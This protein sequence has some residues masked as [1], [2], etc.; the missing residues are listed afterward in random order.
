MDDHFTHALLV[1]RRF[2]GVPLPATDWRIRAM[3]RP[4]GEHIR[5]RLA[6][7]AGRSVLVGLPTRYGREHGSWWYAGALRHTAAWLTSDTIPV[8]GNESIP[9]VDVA[10]LVGSVVPETAEVTLDDGIDL[11]LTDDGTLRPP[12]WWASAKLIAL[13]RPDEPTTLAVHRNH[14]AQD[15]LCQAVYDLT[16]WA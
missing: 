9:H 1:L 14:D 12:Q 15:P 5:I 3:V 6:D 16:D 4:D 8:A 13:L 10:G 2:I 7:T 11:P